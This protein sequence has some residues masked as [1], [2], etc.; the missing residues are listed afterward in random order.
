MQVKLRSQD[1]VRKTLESRLQAIPKNG[2]HVLQK[3]TKRL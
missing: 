1:R 2:E 3:M